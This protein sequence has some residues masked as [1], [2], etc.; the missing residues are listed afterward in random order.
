[1]SGFPI[2]TRCN[3]DGRHISE[4]CAEFVLMEVDTILPLHNYQLSTAIVSVSWTEEFVRTT[5]TLTT[6]NA[7][8][9]PFVSTSVGV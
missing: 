7:R 6:L 8:A 3:D 4:K 1:M 2:L 9:K 5:A